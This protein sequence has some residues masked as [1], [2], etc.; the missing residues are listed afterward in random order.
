MPSSRSTRPATGAKLGGNRFA[1]HLPPSRRPDRVAVKGRFRGDISHRRM[2]AGPPCV[3]GH[4]VPWQE[5]LSGSA[6]HSRFCRPHCSH[7]RGHTSETRQMCARVFR[8]PQT[9]GVAAATHH[10][11][12]TSRRDAGSST[13]AQCEFPECLCMHGLQRPLTTSLALTTRTPETRLLLRLIGT[14]V[15]CGGPKW[16]C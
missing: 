4:R 5:F 10:P 8:S 14:Q 1:A 12:W 6:R 15:F 11:N 3:T 16:C 13:A 9:R 7:D 2:A